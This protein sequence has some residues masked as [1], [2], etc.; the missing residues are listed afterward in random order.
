MATATLNQ[1]SDVAKAVDL[2]LPD[3]RMSIRGLVITKDDLL[4][5]ETRSV[6]NGMIDR[7]PAVIVKCRDVADVITAV[8]FARLH[9]LLTAV[10]GGGHNGGGLGV[11]DD[12]MVIDLSMMKGI[13]MDSTS[14]TIRVEGGCTLGDI[15]HAT[16]VF[17]KA[18]PT[19]IL[20]TT[21][22]GGLTL[23]GGLGHLSRKY[24]LTIDS[25]LE[26]DVVLADGHLIT[27]SEKENS[28]LF[29]AIRGGGG[30]FGIVTSFLFT[31]HDAGTVYGGPMLWPIEDAEE[32]M[33][34]YREF[35]LNASNDHYCYF[36][37]LTV[38]PVA[39]FPAELHLK[40]MCGLL[41][42]NVGDAE[43]STKAAQRFRDLKK[44]AVDFC[45]PIPFNAL[46]GMFDALYPKG[47]QWY[48]KA[49]FVKD[50]TDEAIK[51]NVEYGHQL[52]TPHSTMHLYPIN[53][54]CHDK[55]NN[56]TAFSYR[57]ANWAQ[58]IV[59]VD[60]DPA[61]KEKISS[62]AKAYWEALHPFSL[63]GAYINFMMEEGEAR[64][65]A[66]YRDN[67]RQL[68]RIKR[69][70]DPDNFFKVNQNIKPVTVAEKELE[71]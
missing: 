29:W 23:G 9:N 32:I 52:P 71:H 38:P 60:P 21:G 35:I 50:L 24:G 67:Y 69:K 59:G 33:R 63:G 34:Q 54:A 66:S 16:Q 1:V 31:L 57:D 49:D 6:Y 65:E 14:D 44:P 39:M 25:L 45:G 48:W 47:L 61:N 2:D 70:Y 13:R 41:W 68:A 26:A 19:G 28:D 37:L 40:K 43:K 62:W 55:Q 64:V 46:Q 12:G 5:D 53:G 58:V 30:N 11:C 51:L 4:Y 22:I 18:V 10:R 36:A 17:G 56:E 20:S 42:C 3:F 15:D 8:N 7:H 27:A